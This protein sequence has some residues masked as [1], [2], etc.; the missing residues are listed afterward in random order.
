MK[1][2]ITLRAILLLSIQ[3]TIACDTT[4]GGE[5]C[6]PGLNVVDAGPLEAASRGGKVFSF[7]GHTGSRI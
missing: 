5:N 7:A 1:T 6:F 2:S 4:F 3:A